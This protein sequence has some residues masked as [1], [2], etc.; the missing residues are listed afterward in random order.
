MS[1]DL[2]EAANAA[3]F[4]HCTGQ[5]VYL[6][7]EFLATSYCTSCGGKLRDRDHLT[8][9]DARHKREGKAVHIECLVEYLLSC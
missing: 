7:G 1:D 3:G 9:Y 2:F 4:F 8:N 6:T 5:C